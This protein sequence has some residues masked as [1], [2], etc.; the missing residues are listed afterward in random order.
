MAASSMRVT[1][2]PVLPLPVI[3]THT[4][5]VVR[6]LESYSRGFADG[7]LA[8]GVP[9]SAEVE[10]SEFLVVAHSIYFDPWS[11]VAVC[12]A[13]PECTAISNSPH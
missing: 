12:S 3:P 8:G 9:A 11:V 2:R 7:L 6:S 13:H 5:C 1:P 4:A 10:R